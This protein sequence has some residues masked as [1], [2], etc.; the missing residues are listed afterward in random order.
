MAALKG[1]DSALGPSAATVQNA[2]AQGVRWWGWYLRGPGAYHAWT[3]AEVAV[4]DALEYSLPVWVPA[5]DLS[6][7]PAADY[8]AARSQA[9]SLGW[10]G[11]V[12][13]D[14]E[15]SM[16]GNADLE[17]YVNGW[18]A[19]ARSAGDPEVVYGGGNYVSTAHA[20]W[21]APSQAPPPGECYQAGTGS[22]NG[23][24]VDW[25]YA[26]PAFPLAT[27]TAPAPVPTP[28]P[29]HYPEDNMQS[30]PIRVSIQNGHGWCVSPVS[31]STV[32]NVVAEDIAPS[33]A[34]RYDVVPEYAGFA[35]DAGGN[36]GVL[37]FQPSGDGP[38]PDGNYG[39]LVWSAA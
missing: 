2:I 16:R 9:R 10:F 11:P 6:G 34:G 21:I 37:V 7:N 27:R 39:F 19:A 26:D 15:A 4:L 29:T 14:T 30:T 12:A 31:A 38:A 17:S 23:T 13:L 22:I 20:W 3:D 25:D 32:V 18:C 33:V 35:T 8:A 5:L 24:T 36:N 28:G 1:C